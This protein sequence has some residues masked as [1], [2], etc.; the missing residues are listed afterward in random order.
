MPEAK[1]ALWEY[2]TLGTLFSFH[3]RVGTLMGNIVRF[4][5]DNL[6]ISDISYADRDGLRAYT[7]NLA[8]VTTTANGNDEL[9]VIFG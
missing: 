1:F 3:V 7:V 6:Q 9:R 5:S 4:Q 2:M 8:A